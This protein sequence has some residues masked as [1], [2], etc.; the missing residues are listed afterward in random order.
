MSHDLAHF[1]GLS[2]PPGYNLE[3]SRVTP[4]QATLVTGPLANHRLKTF[5]QSY[6]DLLRNPPLHPESP[7]ASLCAT[8]RTRA[9]SRLAVT[10]HHQ[11]PRTFRVLC[12]TI[13]DWQDHPTARHRVIPVAVATILGSYRLAARLALPSAIPVLPMLLVFG[14]LAR[15]YRTPST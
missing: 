12:L 13:S 9:P 1:T 3:W 5:I 2:K 10:S 8:G 15:F 11:A 7:S 4:I 14:I 6:V